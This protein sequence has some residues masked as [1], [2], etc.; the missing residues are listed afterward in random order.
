MWGI[1]VG[2]CVSTGAARTSTPGVDVARGLTVGDALEVAVQAR[3]EVA[4]CVALGVALVVAV[5][6]GLGEGVGVGDGVWV[7]VT[8]GFFVAAGALGARQKLRLAQRV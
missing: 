8:V 3:V 6:L 5:P 4:D 1:V 7:M 2:V